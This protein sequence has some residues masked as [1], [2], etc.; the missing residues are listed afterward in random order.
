MRVYGKLKRHNDFNRLYRCGKSVKSKNAV[1]LVH[2][3]KIGKTRVGFS[4]TKKIGNAVKR[5]RCRRR[6]KEAVYTY[7]DRLKP[8]YDIVFVA[9]YRECES[10]F[11]ELTKEIGFLLARSDVL[12]K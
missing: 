4:V 6:L 3:N 7:N 9:R 1:I 5:N 12:T 8:S 11:E 10:P 2:S